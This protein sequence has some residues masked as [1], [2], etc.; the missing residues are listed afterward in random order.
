[1]GLI[2]KKVPT[3]GSTRYLNNG[4]TADFWANLSILSSPTNLISA[5]IATSRHIKRGSIPDTK[6][7]KTVPPS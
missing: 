3:V 4:C 2:K 5:F 1:M 7:T 6:P